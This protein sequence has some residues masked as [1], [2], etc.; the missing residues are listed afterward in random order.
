MSLAIQGCMRFLRSVF[1]LKNSLN[2]LFGS[3]E[4]ES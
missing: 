4:R 2:C 1:T 3:Q